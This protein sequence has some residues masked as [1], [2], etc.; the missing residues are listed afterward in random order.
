MDQVKDRHR[1]DQRVGRVFADE[2]DLSVLQAGRSPIRALGLQHLRQQ[3]KG[4]ILQILLELADAAD[5]RRLNAHQSA[6]DLL[7]ALL[8]CD[9]VEV[10]YGDLG[11]NA[12]AHGHLLGDQLR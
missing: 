6:L 1:R 9:P 3:R 7:H 8:I 12:R 2:D 5:L 4:A 10:E 11:G